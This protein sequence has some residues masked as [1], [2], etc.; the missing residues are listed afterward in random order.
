MNSDSESLSGFAAVRYEAD[1]G[2]WASLSASSFKAERGIGA[3]IGASEPRLWRYPDIRRTVVAASGGT[4]FR[5]TPFGR[6][7]L[8]ASM[9]FDQGRTLIESFASRAYDQIVGAEEGDSRTITA[10]LLGDHTLGSRGDL[11]ASFTFSR[12]RGS[13]SIG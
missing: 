10:R 3:E 11:S 1:E 8:E 12:N 4:G 7:D 6:G 5:E 2:A 9:G 13:A